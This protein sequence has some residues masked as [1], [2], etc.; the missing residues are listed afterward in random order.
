MKTP[1]F[2]ESL[3]PLRIPVFGML[4]FATILGNTGSFIRD[5]ASSWLVTDLSTS[6]SAVATIQ[7]MSVLPGFLLAIFA[8]VLSDILDRRRLLIIIQLVLALVSVTLMLLARANAL[9]VQLLTALTFAS[10]TGAALMAPS[11][12]AIVPELV[13][14]DQLKSA[15]ALN[16]L[17][18]N[19]ARAVGP[20]VAG[21]L[22]VALGAPYAYAIDA[23]SDLI[24]VGALLRWHREPSADYTLPERFGGAFRA[25]I[26]FGLASREL[27][28]ILL[29]AA[30]YFLFS[31]AIW[32]LL[33]LIA[34]RLLGG[35]AG[36]YGVLLGAVGLGAILGA[37]LLPRVRARTNTD[38]LMLFAS[39]VTAVIMALIALV[40]HRWLALPA[41]LVL[42]GAWIAALT[43]LSGVTQAILPN[44]V[45]GR[46]LAIYLTVFSGAMAAGSFGWGLVADGLGLAN[47]LLLSAGGLALAAVLLERIPL[48][49]GEAD[50]SAS[51]HW[52]EP[53]VAAPV[54][55]DR[56]PVLVLVEYHI[57][58]GDREGFLRALQAL[59]NERMRDGAYNCGVSEDAADPRRIVEWFFVESWAEHL[60]QHQRVSRADADLQDIVLRYHTGTAPPKVSHFLALK[61]A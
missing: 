45:R 24:V 8:G 2:G 10:G 37:L 47:A 22:L 41:L 40:P 15:I 26:R 5:A 55:G 29:R 28:R 43:S 34:R 58:H 51:S 12:Q 44:W 46:G 48:P 18:V 1:G 9:T 11:W 20:A 61:G 25:G 17:G 6:P 56:G 49:P 21:L 36:L 23:T 42:G 60:R 33:P 7:A 59:G 3:A 54:P 14:R 53:L 57:R 31:S 13:S 50:L 27:Q 32:A 16:S 4:W 19:I 39:A 30:V 35:S 52:P 38:R